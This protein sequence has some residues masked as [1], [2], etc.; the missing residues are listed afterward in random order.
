MPATLTTDQRFARIEKAFA[1]LGREHLALEA[2][3]LELVRL[4][5]ETQPPLFAQHQRT[6]LASHLQEK[7]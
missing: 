1:T 5:F 6:I 4:L 7:Q 2:K 3:Y